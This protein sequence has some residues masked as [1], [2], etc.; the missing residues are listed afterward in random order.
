MRW[1]NRL[2]WST[3]DLPGTQD[4]DSVDL[5][6]NRVLFG[7]ETVSIDDFIF[8]DF[9]QLKAT[10]G[11]LD[12]DGDVS[13]DDAG[14]L[15]QI[16]NAG[17]VWVNGYRDSDLLTIELAGG[18]F[19]NIGSFAGE[20]GISVSEDAQLLL[21]TA[22]GR[23][24]LSS[25]S[26]LTITGSK[27]RVGFDGADGKAATLHLHEDAALSFVADATGLGKIAEFYS[28]AF[29]TSEVASGISLDGDLSI[30]LS[31]LDQKAAGTWTLIDADQ[32]I[33]S[34]D[35]ISITGLGTDRDALIRYDY[36]QD[37]VVL[38]VSEAGQGTGQIQSTTTG[39]ADFVNDT[40]DAA[41][42]TLWTN[43]HAAMPLMTDNPL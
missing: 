4:G 34:F 28:G 25:G 12:I 2:N 41:L 24:D 40:Q 10:S 39:D 5:G 35:D 42:E 20:T 7:S 17:Q 14:N 8:G 6:G 38:L 18:R 11:R 26:S 30:D 19:A 22:G 1:D 43:L 16:D 13:V 29:E 33:G 27:A 36:T 37:E 9:G 15:L 31:A 32:V 3:G 23:F 21:A